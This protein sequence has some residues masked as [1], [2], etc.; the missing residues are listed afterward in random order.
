MFGSCT[1]TLRKEIFNEIGYFDESFLRCSEWDFAIRAAF[2]GA[3]F[4]AV[5]N[6]L[7]C[8]KLMEKSRQNTT[9]VFSETKRKIKILN[10]E[11]FI[12]HQ[13]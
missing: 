13:D 8:I 9:K 5:N 11:I 12:Q 6:Q 10:Q 1:L 3:Y 7:G 2:K 4:V